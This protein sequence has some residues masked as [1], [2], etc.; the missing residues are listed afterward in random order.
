MDGVVSKETLER[1]YTIT[2]SQLR[3]HVQGQAYEIEL[4]NEPGL[5]NKI[6]THFAQ[7]NVRHDAITLLQAMFFAL[8]ETATS[9][10]PIHLH[11]LPL[12]EIRALMV[13]L[14]P[15]TYGYKSLDEFG[16]CF[17]LNGQLKRL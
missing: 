12:E 15:L 6:K 17:A 14:D 11:F 13:K 9:Q 4:Y 7:E 16:E 3:I 2:V 10:D 8:D 1:Q 5:A